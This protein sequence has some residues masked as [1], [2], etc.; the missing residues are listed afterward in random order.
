M[1]IESAVD[2]YIETIRDQQ[3]KKKCRNF[4]L[5]TLL[6]NIKKL[7]EIKKAWPLEVDHIDGNKKAWVIL[8]DSIDQAIRVVQN[9]K[10]AYD[11]IKELF[12]FIEKN[13]NPKLRIDELFHKGKAFSDKAERQLDI[14]KKLQERPMTKDEL[15]KYYWMSRKNLDRDLNDMEIN[16]FELLGQK[17]KLNVDYRSHEGDR[18]VHMYY[19]STA[20]PIF[21]PLNMTQVYAMT[22]G[23][24]KVADGSPYED[25]LNDIS[26]WIYNQL[27]NHAKDII[28]NSIEKQGENL[29]F[30]NVNSEY[31][32]ERTILKKSLR[33]EL[34]YLEKSQK[35][36]IIQYIDPDTGQRETI[37]GHAQYKDRQTIVVE[38]NNK[39]KEIKLDW[40]EKLDYTY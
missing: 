29:E 9:K 2:K 17:I 25:I 11:C 12:L 16:G 23:L 39:H 22:V 8:V 5:N 18:K 27:T 7:A 15:A 10:M 6:P 13:Y 14:I 21:L 31:K 35:K 1:T 30:R 24:K 36:A 38:D 37:I 26:D 20:H 3:E 33:D 19:T 4:L 40:I 32:E 34:I 28:Q